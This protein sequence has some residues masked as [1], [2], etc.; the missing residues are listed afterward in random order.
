MAKCIK[1]KGTGKIQ[2]LDN[3]W[4]ARLVQHDDWEYVSKSD[5]KR[6]RD[7]HGKKPPVEQQ[8]EAAPEQESQ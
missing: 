1:H 7:Q 3:Y 2:R 4:A 8:H 6:W 5:Y